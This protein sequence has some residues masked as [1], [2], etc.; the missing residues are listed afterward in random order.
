MDGK[1]E[2]REDSASAARLPLQAQRSEHPPSPWQAHKWDEAVAFYTGSLQGAD[3][4]GPGQLMYALAK[5][6]ATDFG[7]ETE[8]YHVGAPAN[9][10]IHIFN[11]FNHGL[12]QLLGGALVTTA[13]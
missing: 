1:T 10:N 11:S 2:C 4:Q 6:R 9:A 12:T 8:T 5:K 13:T 3:G 7:T